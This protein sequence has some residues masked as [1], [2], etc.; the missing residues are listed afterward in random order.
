MAIRDSLAGGRPQ[1]T[2]SRWFTP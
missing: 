2:D 1:L